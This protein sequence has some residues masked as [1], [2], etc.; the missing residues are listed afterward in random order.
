MHIKQ[1]QTDLKSSFH[2][3]DH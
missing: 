2:R 1:L 3:Q